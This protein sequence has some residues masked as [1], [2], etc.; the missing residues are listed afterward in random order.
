MKQ[1]NIEKKVKYTYRTVEYYTGTEVIADFK[2]RTFK[3][4]ERIWY[5]EMIPSTAENVVKHKKVFRMS[6]DDFIKYAEEIDENGEVIK[7]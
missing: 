1:E 6:M 2:T 4:V 7:K 5:D 3:E